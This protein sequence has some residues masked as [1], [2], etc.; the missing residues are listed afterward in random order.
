MF[1]LLVHGWMSDEPLWDR[2]RERE[3]MDKLFT[4]WLEIF[5]SSLIWLTLMVVRHRLIK[6]EQ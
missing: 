4:V 3:R 6:M 2:T 5:K 1:V